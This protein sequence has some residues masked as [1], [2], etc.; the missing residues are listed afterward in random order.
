MLRRDRLSHASISYRA[1]TSPA[2]YGN[3]AM[4]RARLSRGL[5]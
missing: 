4:I 2:Q 3:L 5:A 1:V